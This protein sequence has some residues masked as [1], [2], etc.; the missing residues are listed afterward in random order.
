MTAIDKQNLIIEIKIKVTLICYNLFKTS[1]FI[2]L[3]I[4][5][6][7]HQITVMLND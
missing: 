3:Q 1:N 5:C 6:S 7:K 2:I 4:I